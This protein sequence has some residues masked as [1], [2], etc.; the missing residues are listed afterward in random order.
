MEL[1]KSNKLIAEFMGWKMWVENFHGINIMKSPDGMTRDVHGLKYHNSWNWLMRVV[2]KIETTLYK[3]PET[4]KNG[5]FAGKS[6]T[7]C[8]NV[9]YDSREEFQGWYWCIDYF[10]GPIILC[11]DTRV[12]TKREA[13]YD[14]VVKFIQWCKTA[15]S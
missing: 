15:Q 11:N 12:P 7:V 9:E 14:A 8:I 6:D 2:E 4:Y 10:I 1:I 13:T 5:A 3:L